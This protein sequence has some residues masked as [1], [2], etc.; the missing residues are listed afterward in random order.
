MFL[1]LDR[2]LYLTLIKILHLKLT[3]ESFEKSFRFYLVLA[4]NVCVNVRLIGGSARL[5]LDIIEVCNL[6]RFS[7]YLMKI[8][9]GFDS[10][11]YN[12]LIA[13]LKLYGL[14]KNFIDWIKILLA[15]Q[16]SCIIN[17][18]HNTLLLLSWKYFLL[19]Q[20]QTKI[21]MV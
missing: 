9:K 13:I 21:N 19:G 8:E 10:I 12:V 5:I 15:N 4:Q 14:G 3:Q 6:V 18:S 17:G 1:I 11:K 2:F 7:A 20:N 16:E